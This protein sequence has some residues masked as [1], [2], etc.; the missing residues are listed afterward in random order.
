MPIHAVI[1]DY[2]RVLSNPEDAA[3]KAKMIALSGLTEEQL[4]PSYWKFRHAY[5][6]GELNGPSYWNKVAADAGTA[7]TPEQIE[8]LIETDI[9]MWASLNEQMLAWVVALQDAGYPTAILSN[10]GEDMLRYMRQ[11]FG[12]LAH[13]QHHTWSCE[14]GIGKPD[15]AIY[16][17]T[18]ER[19]G[20]APETTLFVDDKP[21]N[22]EAAAQMGLQAI[23]FHS[24]EQVLRELKERGLDSGLPLPGAARGA[25]SSE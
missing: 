11:E 19:L 3:A 4:F 2:G 25:T 10:M 14:I 20:V 6:L 13:F 23:Q 7:F 12:W 18:C 21:E 24:L 17:H 15:P 1:F 5:D 8:N 22:I 9:L 16:T